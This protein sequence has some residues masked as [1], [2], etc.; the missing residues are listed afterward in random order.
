[1]IAKTWS[2]DIA[3][4]AGQP[5]PVISWVMAQCNNETKSQK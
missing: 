4:N 1:M 3:S 2:K 5:V